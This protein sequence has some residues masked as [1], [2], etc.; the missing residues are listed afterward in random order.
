MAKYR[1][2]QTVPHDGPG[3]PVFCC[4]KCLQN[5]NGVIPNIGTKCRWARFNAGVVAT[6]LQHSTR[7]FVSLAQLQVYHTERSPYLFAARCAGLSATADPC[8][9]PVGAFL[10]FMLT[11][12]YVILKQYCATADFKTVVMFY[13]R[14]SREFGNT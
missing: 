7:S 10:V 1:I 5:S 2:T 3:T 12:R 11:G 6:N 8:L 14:F 4:Q 13:C 9:V